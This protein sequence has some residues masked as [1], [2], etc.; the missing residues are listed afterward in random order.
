[1]SYLHFEFQILKKYIEDMPKSLKNGVEAKNGNFLI[2][3]VF[4][5][6]WDA[7]VIV[8]YSFI[9]NENFSFIISI[10]YVISNLM[11]IM[12]MFQFFLLNLFVAWIESSSKAVGNIMDLY[13]FSIISIGK[14]HF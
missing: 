4:P 1:M 13:N 6:G 3:S 2:S 11:A 10:S 7:Y 9:L 14:T 8:F 12:Q 5:V